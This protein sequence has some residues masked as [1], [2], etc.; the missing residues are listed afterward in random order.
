MIQ[1]EKQLL[2]VDLYARLPYNVKVNYN[3]LEGADYTLSVKLLSQF[4]KEKLKPYL[5][6]MSSMT[7]EELKEFAYTILQQPDLDAVRNWQ[8][9]S[10]DLK[11]LTKV[12]D[13]LNKKHFDYR[14]LISMGLA[15]EAPQDMYC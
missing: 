9:L 2:L 8:T 13:W 6:P 11:E 14:G 1:K 10:I 7:E 4:P 15:L 12:L 5:R 3:D